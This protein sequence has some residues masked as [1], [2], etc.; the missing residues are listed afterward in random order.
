MGDLYLEDFTVGRTF[1][2]PSVVVTEADIV[3]FA[4][5]G[6]HTIA[7]TFKLF[8]VRPTRTERTRRQDRW[9]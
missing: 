5:S 8:L 2:S 6:I 9:T 4:A 1:H 3:D 7:L